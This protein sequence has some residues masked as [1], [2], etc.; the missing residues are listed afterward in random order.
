MLYSH[1]NRSVY[2]YM[3]FSKVFYNYYKSHKCF[4]NYYTLAEPC[5]PLY[6]INI[7]HIALLVTLLLLIFINLLFINLLLTLTRSLNPCVPH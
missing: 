5:C 3:F 4:K 7:N 1:Q 6:T 2:P